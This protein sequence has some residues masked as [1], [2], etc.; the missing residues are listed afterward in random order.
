MGINGEAHQ[1][2]PARGKRQEL[3]RWCHRAGVLSAVQRVRTLARAEVRVLAY[4]RVLD[5]GDASRFEFDPAL[6]SASPEHFREQMTYV[7]DR[8]RPVSS[9]ELISL[10]EEGRPLPRNAIIVTFDDGYDDNY[11]IA[12][13]ILRELGVPATFF[14]STGHIDSGI[15]YAY[16]WL[17]HMICM[18]SAPKLE[19][20]EVKLDMVLPSSL[21]RRHA[22]GAEL[23]DRM[24][25]LNDAAQN[26]IIARLEREWSMPRRPHPD[27]RPMNWDQLREMQAAGMD[28]GSHGVNHKM[29]AQLPVTEMIAEVQESKSAL[30]R[31]LGT[32]ARTLSYPVGGPNAYSEAV[33]AASREAGF[34]IA[35]NYIS[36]SNP[37]P[38][39][40]RYALHRLP[41]EYETDIGWFAGIVTWPELF[42]YPTRLRIG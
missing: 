29:L 19:V 5:I 21:N 31:E 17:V 23:L 1:A 28:I 13:P 26:A 42:S 30:D 12:F 27:C 38:V 8:Y 40:D 37:L 10:V 2:Q 20:P 7:R 34:R 22:I 39:A 35:F 9:S 6:V 41:V 4:H 16:D 36:G 24:K 32:T 18:A 11:R 25:W 3:A 14:V 15:P 33:V